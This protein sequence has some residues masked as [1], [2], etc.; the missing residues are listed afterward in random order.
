MCK[1]QPKRPRVT[2][3][4]AA[5]ANMPGHWMLLL[6]L[7]CSLAATNAFLPASHSVLSGALRRA[8][9]AV[10]KHSRAS[11]VS[12]ELPHGSQ[13]PFL[14]SA[15]RGLLQMIAIPYQS[16]GNRKEGSRRVWLDPSPVI[17]RRPASD[18]A[19]PTHPDRRSHN[20]KKRRSVLSTRRNIQ[21]NAHICACE[22]V[23][24]LCA[25]IEHRSLEFNHVNVATA[26][27]KLLPASKSTRG[28]VQQAL[29][30]LEQ[31]AMQTMEVFHKAS[32]SECSPHDGKKELHT[33]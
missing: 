15:K 19:R 24:E 31:R 14:M 28:S 7:A 2:G 4:R 21:L 33:D 26:F 6:L 29:E 18:A 16:G 11:H 10:P 30:M 1:A 13:A 25:L 3:V 20:C 8:V 5:F 12:F 32:R 9:L 17:Y 23:G 22:S 27:R